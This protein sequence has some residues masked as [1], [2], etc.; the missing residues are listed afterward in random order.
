MGAVIWLRRWLAAAV[1]MS[2][3]CSPYLLAQDVSSAA[4][5]KSGQE[6]LPSGEIIFK[7]SV[8]RV[9]V[10]VVVSDSLG[11][12]VSGLTADDF[13]V[14]EDGAP[15]RI[16]SFDVHDFETIS[17]SLPALPASLPAN[18]FVNI[19]KGPERGPLYVV[20]L[21]LLNIEMSD[22][23][24]AR[25]QLLEF[26]RNKPLG[27]RFAIFVLTDHLYQVQGFTEDRNILAEVADPR[28]PHSR[29]PKLFLYADN[30][31][32]YISTPGVLASIGN[33]L[34]DLPGRKNLIWFSSSFPSVIMPDSA[35]ERESLSV[36]D[37]IK[38]ATDSLARARVAV[39]PVD[40]RGV[41]STGPKAAQEGSPKAGDGLAADTMLNATYMTEEELAHG[42]GGR[43]FYSTNDLTGALTA[44]TEAGGHYYALTYSPSNQNYDG[45]LRHI[46]VDLAKKGY[47]VEYRRSYYGIAASNSK[48]EKNASPDLQPIAVAKPSD[49]LSPNMQHGAPVAHQLLFR[50]HIH[51]VAAPTAATREK[52]EQIAEYD[53]G[54]NQKRDSSE[55]KLP[56]SVQLQT[57]QIDYTIAARY[58]LLEIAAAAYD[59]EGQILNSAI[60]RVIEESAQFPSAKTGGAIYR[61]Q[62]KFEVPLKAATV[63]V[64][65]RDVATDNVGALEIKLPLA[66]E[67]ADPKPLESEKKP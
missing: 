7:S 2:L 11:R 17:D 52:M 30:Y 61:V 39:Y 45:R 55:K 47:R 65:V 35:G 13:S 9:I 6:K 60:E 31:R 20:L 12:P 26:V 25:A 44:A 63:R 48:P 36:N 56:R 33:Y 46:R 62:Q 66:P 27:S 18:T 59:D 15:Q 43:A 14:R 34:A 58:P 37:Q 28:N 53:S 5:A 16:R 21:D 40:V 50:A 67:G 38:E 19:P 51:P 3:F 49:S 8:R 57:Y 23:P 4:R 1:A 54:R 29:I 42:T 24:T 10:D 41:V 22:Q 64:A 32:P